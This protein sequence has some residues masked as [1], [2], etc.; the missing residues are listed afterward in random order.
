MRKKQTQAELDVDIRFLLANDRTLLAWIRTALAIE[1][2]GLILMQVHQ[3]HK[4]LGI[5]VVLSGAFV[6]IMG[7]TRYRAAERAIRSGTL[8]HTGIGPLLEVGLVVFLAIGLGVAQSV[9]FE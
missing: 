5:I 9:L 2:G 6:A 7:Y 3:T 1:A 4:W 8:P